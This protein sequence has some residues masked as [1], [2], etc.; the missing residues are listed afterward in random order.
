M[1]SIATARAPISSCWR[2]TRWRNSAPPG[3]SPSVYMR[4]GSDVELRSGSKAL[5]AGW[6][7]SGRTCRGCARFHRAGVLERAMSSIQGWATGRAHRNKPAPLTRGRLQA[8]AVRAPD[9]GARLVA[10]D[11]A[12][13]SGAGILEGNCEAT[14]T[15]EISAR[16]DGQDHGRWGDLV[17]RARGDDQHGPRTPLLMPGRGIEAD[18]PDFAP[19]H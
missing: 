19:I 15:R 9:R 16:G 4:R 12:C 11:H 6:L 18:K 13:R 17:E 8:L 7:W 3:R 10:P 5:F 1:G 2:Q 14:P